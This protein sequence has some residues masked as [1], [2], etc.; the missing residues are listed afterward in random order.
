VY[1]VVLLRQI[2]LFSR[3]S[4]HFRGSPNTMN[5]GRLATWFC[6]VSRI[7]QRNID[8]TSG[9]RQDSKQSGKSN[10]SNS[11]NDR[12]GR[13]ALRYITVKWLLVLSTLTGHLEL[14]PSDLVIARYRLSVVNHSG[15]ASLTIKSTLLDHNPYGNLQCPLIF[16]FQPLIIFV[17][18]FNCLCVY[19]V[20]S[21]VL[22]VIVQCRWAQSV[23]WLRIKRTIYLRYS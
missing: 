8:G 9:I 14:V 19:I 12:P 18:R 16:T 1:V 23:V 15:R 21:F 22:H 5:V 6:Y 20:Y 17:M 10:I 11:S 7:H 13:P 4:K 3:P 2:L